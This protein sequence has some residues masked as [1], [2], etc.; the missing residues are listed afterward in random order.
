M[1]DIAGQSCDTA[2]KN[3]LSSGVLK[4][5]D[6]PFEMVDVMSTAD[7]GLVMAYP[8]TSERAGH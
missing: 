5:L 1:L 7:Q 4:G 2:S 6:N 3:K 8:H